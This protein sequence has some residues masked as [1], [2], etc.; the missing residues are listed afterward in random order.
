MKPM[1]TD[2]NTAG[3]LAG[4]SRRPFLAMSAL[5]FAVLALL[6]SQSFLP[7]RIHFN[8]DGPLG[9]QAAACYQMPA[10]FTGVWVDLNTIGVRGGTPTPTLTYLI[11]LVL[12]PLLFAKFYAPLALLFL[13]ASAWLFFRQLG[14]APLACL[15]AGLAAALNSL[16]FSTAC[17]GVASHSIT[18]GFE[19]LAL[20][21]VVNPSP[22]FRGVKLALAG[23]AVGLGIM[24]GADIGAIFSIFVAAFV[25]FQALAR[26]EAAL[27]RRAVSGS[28]C[29]LVIACFAALVAAQTLTDLIGTQ[30]KGVAGMQQDAETKARRWD[31]ATQWSLPKR[32]TLGLVVP[33]LFGYRMDTPDGGNYWGAAGR[34][35]AWDRYFASGQ[36]GQPPGPNQYLRYSGG[37]IYS[38]VLVVLVAVWAWAQALR[39]KGSVFTLA[40]RKHLWFW[41]G[42]MLVSLL[43]AFGRHAP[44]YQFLYALPYFSTI[45]NPAK[46]MDVFNW[47][48]V[49]L[50]AYGVHGL[51]KR[52][53]E[54]TA[55]WPGSLSEHLG[56]WWSKVGG[57]DRKWT[58]GCIVAVGL[59]VLGWLI[60][61]SSRTGLE[62]YL[63]SVR[64]DPESAKAVA[65]FSIRQV[66]WFVLFLLPATSLVVLVLSGYFAGPR[67]KWGGVLMGLLLAVDLGRA[68]QPWI[69]YLDYPQKYASN[70][71]IDLLR[72]KP[73]E[74]RVAILPK[75]IQ[76]AFKLPPPLL[77]TEQFLDQLH[78]VEWAQHHFQYYNVQSLD[79][80]QM[81]RMPEDLAAF[82]GALQFQ[83]TQDTLYLV[84]RKWQL[85]N[86]RYLLGA[87]AFLPLL[88][89]QFDPGQQR[90]RI[91]TQFD[92]TNKPGVTA[93]TR[94]E[95]LTAVISTNGNYALLEF[96]GAL[97]RAQLFA[98]WQA[99]T[100]DQAT[101]KE[102]A[103]VSFDPTRTV[104]VANPIPAPPVGAATNQ[105]AGT[106]EF[107]R[108]APKDIVL[109]ARADAP[110]VLL[111]CDKYDP[112][113][114]VWVDGKQEGLLRCN[115]IVRGVY[116]APGQH[117]LEFRFRPPI[118]ALYVTWAATAL[119][120][121]LCGLLVVSKDKGSGSNQ[122]AEKKPAK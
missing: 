63:Q 51:S 5:L 113:W 115:Y 108:Y 6:F 59:S 35:P 57:F 26:D 40:N 28:V 23:M 112:N 122:P 83:G 20:A 39:K 71:V 110:S 67:A 32:E 33:G 42:V 99:S 46:F 56:N 44:F 78:G 102:L 77:S 100:N 45:R 104:L 17:W 96:T 29:V 10:A 21:A 24:E 107:A 114:Q 117:T 76:V 79:I 72:E 1:T 62:T 48:L 91:A 31:E 52:H 30:I 37:G 69:I 25:M 47:A 106:V 111:L 22:R 8:N 3:L 68:N 105:N 118:G 12:G 49:V 14:L 15:L 103:S 65:G 36:Q 16:F 60:Y 89:Q 93:A 34:D 75:W 109:K 9:V 50:F 66:G 92:I 61:S 87:T 38:G 116:L 74:H 70:P 120:L 98:N 88:N 18:F 73:F 13:G 19:Y 121:V 86:T 2:K 27:A 54:P 58:T 101:L 64:F 119:G 82:E 94:L 81:P 4:A 90:F 41:L 95:E 55:A 85:T 97:P 43:L 53:L 84:A 80:V 11:K 7:G